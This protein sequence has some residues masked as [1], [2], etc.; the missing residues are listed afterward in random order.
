MRTISLALLLA[1]C[2]P[3]SFQ[4]YLDTAPIRVGNAPEKFRAPKYGQSMVALN[5]ELGGKPASRVVA[6]GG[7]GTPI[8]F[9]RSYSDGKLS[10]GTFLRCKNEIECADAQD[11]GLVMIPF[12][13]F[14]SSTDD[15]RQLC[16]YSPANAT[17]SSDPMDA[18]LGGNGYV[19]CE[20]PSNRPQSFNL[21]RQ[22]TDVRGDNGTL[23]YSGFGL[24]PAHPLGVVVLGVHAIDNRTSAPRNGGLYVQPDL[25]FDE[26][27]GKYTAHFLG[28]VPLIDPSTGKA[29]SDADDAA[30]FGA[31]VAG[32]VDGKDFTFAI[33]QPSKR[34][35]IVGRYE[36]S[37]TGDVLSKFRV[38]ACIDSEATGFGAVLQVGDISGDGAPELIVG[39]DETKLFVYDGRS[40]P[41]PAS[42]DACPPWNA[43]PI[44]LPCPVQ[45]GVS[46]DGFGMALAIGDVDADGTGDLII[47]APLAE[48]AGKPEVGA[49]WIVPGAEAGPDRDRAIALTVPSEANAHFG[50]NVA[51][52]HTK[53]RDEPVASAPGVAQVFT[54]MCTPLEQGLGGSDLC[55]D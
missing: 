23:H 48:V 36:D 10:E 18:R 24:P 30:D 46:C 16:V 31:Q 39:G 3:S 8:V 35:V 6:S 42:G 52:L 51:A 2:N 20:E 15:V 12:Q 1:G 27:E 25:I 40:L 5:G 19:A 13:T 14:G 55:L 50:W 21:G 44:E 28:L 34:R 43:A 7:G 41:A 32:A 4:D 11:I 33:A 38:H 47:G 53:E 37:G 49:V 54:I 17:K 9:T 26:S 29:F 22:I 45:D